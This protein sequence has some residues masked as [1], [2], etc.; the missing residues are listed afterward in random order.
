MALSSDF[1]LNR[2]REKKA[3][4][5]EKR[6]WPTAQIANKAKYNE[7]SNHISD[8]RIKK[9]RKWKQIG[10]HGSKS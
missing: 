4:Q 10:N 1:R 8:H 9:L 5:E 2:H 7:K 3:S 6:K